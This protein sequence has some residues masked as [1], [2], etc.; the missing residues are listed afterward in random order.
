MKVSALFAD[1]EVAVS[2]GDVEVSSLEY[3]S[4]RVQPGSLFA[5]W[6]GTAS[7]GHDFIPSALKSGARCILCQRPV[8]TGEATRVVAQ[9][10]RL[11][12][13]RAAR[14]Y[15]RDPAASLRTVGITGTNG[16]TTTAHLVAGILEAA[17]DR[18]GVLGTLGLSFA[19]QNQA[20]QLTTPE[21]VDLVRLLAELCNASAT[22]LCMEVSSHAL[23]QHRVAVVRFDVAVF[24]NLTL[25][26]L[27]Y[28]GSL[29]AYFEAKSQLL[30]LLKAGGRAVVN[31]DDPWMK[32]LA[33]E[34]VTTFSSAD[35]N[36]GA[37]VRL[38]SAEL[39]SKGTTLTAD[40]PLGRV[41]LFSPLVGRFNIENLLAAVAV[42]V[43]LG[44]KW[45]TIAA[46]LAQVAHVPGRLERVS[47]PG[48][49]L[50]L[51]DYAHTP[52]ALAKALA[53]VREVCAGRLLCVFGCGGDRDRHKRPLMG[54]KVAAGADWA[55]L[56]SD[57]PRT[58]DAAVIAEEV[59]PG[60]EGAGCK[61]SDSAAQHGYRIVLD[62]A[63]AIRTALLEAGPEDAVLVAGKGHEDYQIVGTEKRPFDDREV[64]RSVLATWPDA[65]SVVDHEIGG[66]A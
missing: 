43:A 14:R 47:G 28:H 60:L 11:T 12:F 55:V 24:L 44:I 57:N 30:H 20:T 54:A 10:V 36:Q 6:P 41:T 33:G 48:Q 3:D 38:C 34:G 64:A 13:A 5:A 62:R 49:P 21:S 9:N 42:G 32:R 51:V 66:K 52:D 16:K 15:Y 53:S 19:E 2:G 4:R 59:R 8:E 18:V 17:G 26:H 45:E 61:R 50:V 63:D 39:S 7:D 23:S 40:T 46:G 1:M 25:D 56:T 27:D 29:E 22:A 37:D 65:R 31:V 35:G 58:E